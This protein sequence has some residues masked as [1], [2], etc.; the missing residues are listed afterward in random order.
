MKGDSALTFERGRYDVSGMTV[1]PV[2]IL[3]SISKLVLYTQKLT[4]EE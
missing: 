3:M 2:S 1:L 4:S